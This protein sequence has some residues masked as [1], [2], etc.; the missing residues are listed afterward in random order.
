MNSMESPEEYYPRV[1]SVRTA[2]LGISTIQY[3]RH[4]PTQCLE[5]ASE[6]SVAKY[7]KVGGLIAH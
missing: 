2:M 3:S 7:H 4:V 6:T 5:V 1:L